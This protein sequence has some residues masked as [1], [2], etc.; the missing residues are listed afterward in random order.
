MCGG[1]ASTRRV[2]MNEVIE[3][4]VP[5]PKR[6]S[7]YAVLEKLEVGQSAVIDVPRSSSLS[8][9]RS[10]LYK[11]SP[12]MQLTMKK[13]PSKLHCPECKRKGTVT[14]F[15]VGEGAAFIEHADKNHPHLEVRPEVWGVRVWRIDDIK[16]SAG[17][18]AQAPES[19]NGPDASPQPQEE[20][21]AQA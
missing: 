7:K 3:N 19:I 9:T 14:T 21:P 2:Q 17:Q 6:E 15:D 16:P 4:G 18:L 11:K 12:G 20:T 8:K 5:I 10:N 13:E 1:V